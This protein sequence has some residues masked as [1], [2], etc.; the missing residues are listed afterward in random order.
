[1]FPLS[2]LCDHMYAQMLTTNFLC[3]CTRACVCRIEPLGHCINYFA[4]NSCVLY[5]DSTLAKVGLAKNA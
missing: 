5:E 1:M 3:V 4:C 2:S